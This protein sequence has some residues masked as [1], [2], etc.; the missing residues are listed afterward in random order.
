MVR[1]SSTL[2]SFRLN[3]QL[4]IL[5]LFLFFVFFLFI[6]LFSF[7]TVPVLHDL[8]FVFSFPFPFL[9][10]HANPLPLH[11]LFI[12]PFRLSIP[13]SMHGFSGIMASAANYQLEVCFSL[14]PVLTHNTHQP[15][16][17]PSFTSFIRRTYN[18]FTQTVFIRIFLWYFFKNVC[19]F[20]CECAG[21]ENNRQTVCMRTSTCT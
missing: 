15:I 1:K 21:C 7:T 19:G 8:Y 10:G 3:A 20:M 13:S 2:L 5:V 18:I 17:F 6:L 11:Q 9:L 14:L 4:Y 16:R 12:S